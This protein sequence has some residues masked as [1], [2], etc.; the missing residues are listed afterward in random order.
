MRPAITQFTD[1]L[2]VLT[3]TQ[4]KP[5]VERMKLIH[6]N[7]FHEAF[8]NGD[9]RGVSFED[10]HLSGVDF[11]G[12]NLLQTRWND[13]SN[14]AGCRFDGAL[15]DRGILKAGGL[16]E[17]FFDHLQAD[18][19]AEWKA[20]KELPLG[21]HL[22]DL[23][24]GQV[25]K[26]KPP[27]YVA[28]IK[29]APDFATARYWLEQME[30][31]GLVPHCGL[32]TI[33]IAKRRETET[34]D[35]IRDLVLPLVESGQADKQ[36]IN[37]ALGNVDNETSAQYWFDTLSIMGFKPDIFSYNSLIRIRNFEGGRA[38]I[39]Q[40]EDAGIKPDRHSY[41]PLIRNAPTFQVALSLIE[42][43]KRKDIELGIIDYYALMFAANGIEEVRRAKEEM[44]RAGYA[45]N[46]DAYNRMIN[47]VLDFDTAALIFEEMLARGLLPDS[48]TAK[49]L[50]SRCKTAEHAAKAFRLLGEVSDFPSLTQVKITLLN[51]D[52]SGPEGTYQSVF[53]KIDADMGFMEAV[54][55][56]MNYCIPYG[57]DLFSELFEDKS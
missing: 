13:V 48:Y 36:L 32:V 43:M 14:I 37:A 27:Q 35:A 20:T 44:I 46:S 19:I 6:G 45:L 49:A 30:D 11:T 39:A 25:A 4:D 29:A 26:Y 5:I 21:L 47:G 50:L 15:I 55:G 7:A 33:V 3:E 31:G 10:Q 53:S 8:A 54:R 9:W 38:I 23:P 24:A 22:G 12:C 56:L 52:P 51:C 57:G 34:D 2:S 18:L 17:A 16:T 40:I 42:E 41:N 28:L 1:L